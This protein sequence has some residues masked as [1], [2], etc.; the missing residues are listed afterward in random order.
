K[1]L[2]HWEMRREVPYL[3]ERRRVQGEGCRMQGNGAVLPY[4]PY[5]EWVLRVVQI[6]G[7]LGPA[8]GGEEARG[9]NRAAYCG[10]VAAFGKA[11]ARHH[12]C[13]WAHGALNHPQLL[14]MAHATRDGLQELTRVWMAWLSEDSF[15]CAGLHERARIHNEH[16]VAH[17][18]DN[19]KIV[20]DQQQGH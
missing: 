18:V 3:D 4:F 7:D 6:A 5:G 2:F 14:I 16:T 20:R 17:L 15:T 11:A 10:I 13:G 12:V 1:P 8:R 9:C 19:T